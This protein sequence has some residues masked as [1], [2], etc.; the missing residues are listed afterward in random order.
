MNEYIYNLTEFTNNSCNASQLIREVED[1]A[2]TIAL[3][4][5]DTTSTTVSIWFKAELSGGEE[6]LLDSLIA[7]HIALADV[8]DTVEVKIVENAATLKD[9]DDNQKVTIQPRVGSGATLIT[10]NFGDPCTWYEKSVLVSNEVLTPKVGG[11]YDIYECINNNVID[12]EHGRLT[13]DN[14]IDQKYKIQVKVNDIV[15]TT[16]FTFNYELGEITFQTPLTVSD[17]V[18]LTYY[19]ATTNEFTIIPTTGKKLKVEHVELQFS[20]DIDMHGKTQCHFE[21]R[22]YNPANLPNKMTYKTA[23]YKNL[24]NFIDESNNKMFNTVPAR[25][26]MTKDMDIFVWEYPVSRIMKSTQ[27]AEVLIYMLDVDPNSPTY[28]LKTKAI[29]NK[30]GNNLERAVATFYCLSE[31]DV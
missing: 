14:R 12:I 29:K 20:V 21:E 8:P 24:M 10:H 5:I 16:G 3:D 11:V 15:V 19:Y 2:I 7:N 25:D 9:A 27:G 30:D 13:F 28:G 18:K 23:I 22:G 6:T 4:R 26:N 17:E 1:S 31:N